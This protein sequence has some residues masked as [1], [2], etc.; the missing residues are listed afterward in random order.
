VVNLDLHI[1]GPGSNSAAASGT[2]DISKQAIVTARKLV[3]LETQTRAN[4]R[5]IGRQAD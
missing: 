3:V 4:T 5:S 1:A 2:V